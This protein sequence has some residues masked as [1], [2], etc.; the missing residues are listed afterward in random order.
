MESPKDE[1]PSIPFLKNL[2]SRCDPNGNIQIEV[3]SEIELI[4]ISEINSLPS[5]L[6]NHKDGG[7]FFGPSIVNETPEVPA[8]GVK[9]SVGALDKQTICREIET[10]S[11]RP[12]FMI[13][14]GDCV[15]PLWKLKE[16]V[17]GEF[18]SIDVY[19]KKVRA[20]W[21]KEGE[22]VS[23]ARLPGTG[24]GQFKARI[25]PE[26]S[27][28]EAEYSLGNLE[29]GFLLRRQSPE[30]A[31]QSFSPRAAAPTLP[32]VTGEGQE[33]GQKGNEKGPGRADQE[34]G[35]D[36][37]G[38]PQQGKPKVRGSELTGVPT[39]QN[40]EYRNLLPEKSNGWV[41]FHR[42]QLGHWVSEDKPWCAGYAWSYL[43]AQANHRA[44]NAGFRG[45]YI[46]LERGQ[47]ITSK[48]RLRAVFS[49]GKIR[50]EN[51]LKRLISDN[52][53]AVQSTK[54]F[55]VITICNYE[56][57][58]GRVESNQPTERPT[59]QPT[60]NEPARNGSP[61]ISQPTGS[62]QPAINKKK[63][64]LIHPNCPPVISD[65]QD[66]QIPEKPAGRRRPE[67]PEDSIPYKLTRYLWKLIQENFPKF[68]LPNLQ[69]WA[70]NV[71]RMI[72]LDNREPDD[73]GRVIAW[74]Q[75]DSFWKSNI[76]S[77]EKLRKQ[78]DTIQAKMGGFK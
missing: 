54:R 66:F 65:Q 13:D 55:M 60:Q 33:G 44:G 31:S 68:K 40:G 10:F 74:A 21:G 25:I 9:V 2:F 57:Y 32:E 64:K 73:I 28:P 37:E 51:F 6:E 56:R 12:S 15:Y 16:P 49:W 43:Y 72:R 75:R 78:F 11:L 38:P 34:A 20:F 1:H 53:I 29:A 50:L 52:M 58:Q 4:S 41:K 36:R 71:D 77:T 39:S 69:K 26:L 45:E 35:P 46:P 70:L 7:A 76:L 17:T 59:D 19:R 3:D 27:F 61:S 8:I 18:P 5:L 23:V 14:S 47:F 62:Q 22:L 42:D 24:N 30:G 48:C 67:Y 63:E